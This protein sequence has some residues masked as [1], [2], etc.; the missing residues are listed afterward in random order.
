[1]RK[2]LKLLASLATFCLALCVLCFGVFAA[3]KVTYT[4]SGTISYEVKD[5]YAKVKTY[6]YSSDYQYATASALKADA[7]L[8]ETKDVSSTPTGLNGTLSPVDE[9]PEVNSSQ[10]IYSDELSDIS[11]NYTTQ[12]TET[13]PISLTYFV[14]I[15]VENL[16]AE[17]S[18]YIKIVDK[19][20]NTMDSTNSFI[21]RTED[22]TD[23]VHQD[24]RKNV[25]IAYS[26]YDSTKSI[27]PAV[28]F[29]YSIEVGLSEEYNPLKA[30]T[31]NNYYYVE[32]GDFYGNPIRWRLLSIDG[33]QTKYTAFDAN[34]LPTGDGV[35]IQETITAQQYTI[36]GR[37]DMYATY[38]ERN[39]D[40]SVN[41]CA[42]NAYGSLDGT[43]Y[44]TD[45]DGY[46]VGDTDKDGVI[47]EG[48]NF[49]VANDYFTSRVRNYLNDT[50]DA[51]KY[52]ITSG[53]PPYIIDKTK[54]A[55][56]LVNDYD[57]DITEN[58]GNYVYNKIKPRTLDSLKTNMM[59]NTEDY[60]VW[61]FTDATVPSV[62]TGKVTKDDVTGD[63]FWLLSVDEVLRLIA[64]VTDNT[65]D[66]D[67]YSNFVWGE[68]EGWVAGGLIAPYWWLRSPHSTNSSRAYNVFSD[69][70]CG[71]NSTRNSYHVAR[72]AFQ[73]AI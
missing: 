35:F 49:V 29:E 17:K 66:S 42:F 3:I 8:L 45:D 19:L 36:N 64:G 33:G 27:S 5:A 30:D 10:N 73:L 32:M 69:G 11:I 18:Q 53:P 56:C 60:E 20:N 28:G 51:Y 50:S 39:D 65:W 26:L 15:S 24:S 2:K 48:E 57:I 34:T 40:M 54:D 12:A 22:I 59:S 25:V 47:D 14:V 38:T 9:G 43:Y 6:V 4:I 62:A 67:V 61:T 16:S 31:N 72:A 37:G 70:S 7:Q 13:K 71:D 52:V 23:L 41:A 58:T 1:M 46:F 63:R 68:Y 21:Y 44:A 55:S